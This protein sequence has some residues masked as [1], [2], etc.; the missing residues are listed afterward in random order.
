MWLRTTNTQTQE[1]KQPFIEE[2]V[3][4]AENGAFQVSEAVAERLLTEADPASYDQSEAP[5]DVEYVS[6]EDVE[7][8]ERLFPSVEQHTHEADT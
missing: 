5:D 2:S 8:A 4:V 6:I 1:F 3:S 7:G